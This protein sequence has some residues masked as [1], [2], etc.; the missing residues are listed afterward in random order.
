MRKI[1]LKNIVAF[2]C[3]LVSI[4]TVSA[5]PVITNFSPKSGPT[6]AAGSTTVTI[7]G[8]GFSTTSANN[9][10][11]FGEVQATVTAA[12][13]TQLTVTAP[14]GATWQ[15]ISVNVGGLTAYSYSVANP[16]IP[17]FATKNSITSS[18]F[19]L[20]VDFTAGTNP[21]SGGN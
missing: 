5:T 17:T 11:Y 20:K 7:T 10:V 4:C 9:I 16:F 6:G 1:I 12:T 18:D 8:T 15:N 13:T 21:R 14:A 19:A 2:S 3:V